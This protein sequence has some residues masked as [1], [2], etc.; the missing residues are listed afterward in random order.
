[1][2]EVLAQVCV[3]VAA[4]LFLSLSLRAV[5]SHLG[6]SLLTDALRW[7]RSVKVPSAVGPP[8]RARPSPSRPHT[9]TEEELPEAGACFSEPHGCCLFLTLCQ[10]SASR[11]GPADVTP[12]FPF[13]ATE[14]KSQASL[15]AVG[16]CLLGTWA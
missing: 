8:C 2:G 14:Q 5:S 3:G 7:H 9:V 16:I 15:W 10:C 11:S 6:S 13:G 12:F 4:V 1:M